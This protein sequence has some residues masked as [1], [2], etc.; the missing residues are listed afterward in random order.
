M[1]T[2][3]CQTWQHLPDYGAYHVTLIADPALPSKWQAGEDT[4]YLLVFEG[5]QPDEWMPET[6][7]QRMLTS[8][9]SEALPI[10]ILD[11]WHESL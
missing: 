6:Q 10:P 1:P 3:Y 2:H 8:R 5:G 7:A 11:E 4:I 9:L